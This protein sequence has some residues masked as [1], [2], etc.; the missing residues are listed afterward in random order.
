MLN[1]EAKFSDSSLDANHTAWKFP[2]GSTKVDRYRIKISLVQL[3]QVVAGGNTSAT[4]Q[5]QHFAGART[6]LNC[7]ARLNQWRMLDAA[8]FEG[9]G[10]LMKVGSFVPS[11]QMG[12]S[13]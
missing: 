11:G 7:R 8:C 5:Q 13:N 1:L 12:F 10:H 6:Q 9:Q 2:P 4:R 3:L